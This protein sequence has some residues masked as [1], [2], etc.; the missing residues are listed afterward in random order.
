MSS[1]TSHE[2]EADLS[3]NFSPIKPKIAH[4]SVESDIFIFNE[5]V[6]IREVLLFLDA[7]WVC[8]QFSL[9]IL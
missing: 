2:V 4:P 7:I 8:G 6:S 5:K 9:I 1:S 3:S